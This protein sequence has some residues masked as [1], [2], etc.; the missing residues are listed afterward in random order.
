MI[1]RLNKYLS[2][3]GVASRRK[4]DE[5]IQSGIVSVN[6]RRIVELGTKINTETD[7]VRVGKRVVRQ[8]GKRYII[9]NKPRLCLTTL[10]EDGE[11]RRTVGE[12]VRDV[13]ERVF[14]VG[15]LDYDAEGLLILTNDGEL[16]N[17]IHHPSFRIEKLYRAVVR[18][19]VTPKDIEGMRRGATLEDGRAVPDSI[20]AIRSEEGMTHLLISFHEGRSHLVKRFLASFGF[21]VMR[22]KRIRIGP[23]ALGDLPKGMWREMTDEEIARLKGEARRAARIKLDEEGKEPRTGT[24]RFSKVE[25]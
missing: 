16:A 14:P 23:I 3:C 21:P 1:V 20:R 25:T 2:M 5:F 11:G 10:G 7:V 18:G 12:L 8:E 9:L 22:L 4:A 15:R 13:P 17:L 24:Y 19:V 6:G